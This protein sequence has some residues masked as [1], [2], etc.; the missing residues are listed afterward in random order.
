VTRFHIT[1]LPH[2]QN[3]IY[4]FTFYQEWA[5]DPM[6]CT[7]YFPCRMAGLQLFHD[8]VSKSHKWTIGTIQSPWLVWDFIDSLPAVISLNLEWFECREEPRRAI[9]WS[10]DYIYLSSPFNTPMHPPPHTTCDSY[11]YLLEK[12]AQNKA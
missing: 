3:Q 6:Y 1:W 2:T 12:V 4:D 7:L 11:Y 5:T 9:T 8:F 10:L